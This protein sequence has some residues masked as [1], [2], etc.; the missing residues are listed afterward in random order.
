MDLESLKDLL[1]TAIRDHWTEA[2]GAL[3]MLLV[4]RLWGRRRARR[5]WAKKQFLHRLMI[6]LNTL[7][8]RDGQKVLQIR[9]ILEKDIQDVFLNSVAVD[10]VLQ[11]AERT[12]VEDPILPL[13]ADDRWPLLNAVLNEVAEAFSAGTLAADMGVRVARKRYVICLTN[14][15]AGPVRAQKIRAMMVQKDLLT[16]GAFEGDVAIEAE[17]HITRK[18]TLRVMRE[19]HAK[20][21]D[22]FLDVELTIPDPTAA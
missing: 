1:F 20:R 14:E 11:A 16:S 4:G 10:K 3:V 19:A 18:D 9:T 5:D 8:D 6:S 2:V 21:P 15:I 22:M 17:N 7:G 13:S 12:T